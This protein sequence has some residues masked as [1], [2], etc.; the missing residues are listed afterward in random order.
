[1]LT[2]FRL[3]LACRVLPAGFLVVRKW[4]EGRVMFDSEG[5][6]A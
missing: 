5:E 3:W 1:M 2:R 6:D 4:V